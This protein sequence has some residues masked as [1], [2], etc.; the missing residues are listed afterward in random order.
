MDL[1]RYSFGTG[2]RFGKEGIAQLKA[3]LKLEE[4]GVEVTPVWNK[5]NREHETVGSDPQSFRKEANE[6]VRKLGFKRDYFVDADH[7][8]L[9]T[10]DPYIEVSDFFTIDVAKFIGRDAPEK[11]KQ[12]FLKFFNKYTEGFQI[13]GIDQKFRIS[14]DELQQMLKSFLFAMKR[15]GE[16]SAHIS[17]K[18][19]TAFHI[20]VSI[21]EVDKP[22]SPVELFFIL[23]AL[24]HYQVPV[25]TIAPKF[26]GEFNKG[27]DYRGDL[28][29]FAREFE[30]DLLVLAFAVKEFGLPEN[31]K[32][33]VHSGSDKFS[34]YPVMQRLIQ[35]H[36]AGLHLKTAGTSWLEELIGLAESEGEAFQFCRELYAGA[37]ERYEELTKDYTSVLS[38][39]RR[40]LP[41]PGDFRSGKEYADALR[42]DPDNPSYNPDF[43]QLMHCAYKL[44][45]ERDEEFFAL[46]EKNRERIEE[47]VTHNLF[48]RHLK[49]LFLS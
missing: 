41:A 20:E 1:G 7:I 38:I 29:Q 18:K 35:K 26:T 2:D 48:E 13:D 17:S 42:H 9:E 45:A 14:E 6:A 49:P 31:L 12:D 21:D 47:N 37:L 16:I 27:V 5:S 33:S 8:D 43:R 36:R 30:E 11:E 46:L 3:V 19:G 40:Q 15:A 24:A 28:D 32:L 25:N 22:Q 34:I 10:V 4:A 23:A 39:D 44:A